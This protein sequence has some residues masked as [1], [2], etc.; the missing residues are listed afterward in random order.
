LVPEEVAPAA[1]ELHVLGAVAEV[2]E[3]FD[4]FPDREVDDLQVVAERFDTGG[5]AGLVLEAPSVPCTDLRHRVDPGQVQ[6]EVVDKR[7]VD[8]CP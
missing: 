8:R 5:V 2:G 1:Q 6:S 3:R 4:R 7:V